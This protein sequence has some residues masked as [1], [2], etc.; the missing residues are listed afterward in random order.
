MSDLDY[1]GNDSDL[2][3]EVRDAMAG[4]DTSKIPDDTITQ[5]ANKFVIPFIN[6]ITDSL[7]SND[8]QDA[9]DNAVVAMTAERAFAAWLTFTRLRD[10]EI[11]TFVDPDSYK[12]D[13][14]ERT[15]MALRVLGTTRPSNI[16]NTVVTITHDGKK[17]KVDLDK[18]W[19]EQ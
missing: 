6:D 14:E 11:E 3:T 2:I 10:R 18:H 13:L 9:F 5:E 19:E 16:P 1:S 7:N 17:R 12:S 8:D 4:L 15:D